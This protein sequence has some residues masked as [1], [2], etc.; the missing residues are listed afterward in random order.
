MFDDY[1]CK[2]CGITG[3]FH[4]SSCS[5]VKPFPPLGVQGWICPKCGRGNAPHSNSCPCIPYPEYKVTC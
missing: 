4:K 3:G 2:E 1:K 5:S